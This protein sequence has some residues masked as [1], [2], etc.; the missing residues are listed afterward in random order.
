VIA[1]NL[2]CARGHQFEGWFRDSAAY[3]VQEAGGTL[4]CPVCGDVHVRKAIMS[5]SVKTTVTKSK[6][7]DLTPGTAP[8]PTRQQYV[9][10]LRKFIAEN[11]EYVGPRFAEEA[12]KMHY[13]EAEQR[14][15]YGESTLGEAKELI[16]E[17]IDVAPIPP[18]PDDL[19]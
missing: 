19:N 13:G 18:D 5:P 7:R 1:Y 15:I 14:H 4:A 11:A 16:E 12:R 2:A 9:A 6:G 17:G 3:D 8:Q 10:G